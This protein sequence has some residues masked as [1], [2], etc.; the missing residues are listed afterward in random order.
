MSGIYYDT[1]GGPH[2][3]CHPFPPEVQSTLVSCSNPT[4]TITNS[5]LEHAAAIGQTAI[6]AN[7]HNVLHCHH[8]RRNLDNTPTTSC[9]NKGTVT[10]QGPAVGLCHL[11]CAH[12]RHHRHCLKAGFLP[13]EVNVMSDDGS[14]L[15]HLSDT[16][17]VSHF[18][19]HCP[20]PMP[21]VLHHLPSQTDSLVISALVCK[22]PAIPLPGKLSTPRNAPS[23][24]GQPSVQTLVVPTPSIPW[25]T[26]KQSTSSSSCT[27]SGA[28]SHW[29]P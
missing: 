2:L 17:L 21:W 24:A 25:T 4:G 8:P 9:V 13:G 6:M 14:R 1:L 22:Q 26:K 7:D 10:S 3:W 29:R 15:Q 23:T 20:Q 28:Q 11:A 18:E 5:D 27:A 12:Q 19:Q 16:A